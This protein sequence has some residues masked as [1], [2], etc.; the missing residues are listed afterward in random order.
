MWGRVVGAVS[1]DAFTRSWRSHFSASLIQSII[2]IVEGDVNR[3][4]ILPVVQIFLL[5]RPLCAQLPPRLERCLPY[6]TLAQEISQMQEKI[7][8][9]E[10]KP[11]PSPRVVIASVQYVLKTQIPASVRDR[12]NWSIKS[13]RL[14]DDPELSWLKEMEEVGMR[15]ALQDSGYFKAEVKANARLIDGNE[16]RRRYALT[17]YID[18][19]WLYKLG[20][21]RFERVDGNKILSF[22]VGE[23]RKQVQM[24]RG[25]V[26]NVSKIRDGIEE[27]SG[28]YATEGYIDMTMEP[29][30]QNDDDGGPIDLILKV[31]EEKQYHLGKVEFLGLSGESQN[32]LTPKLRPG[33]VFNKEI[34]D[35]ILESNKALVPLDASR[36]DVSL[37]RNVEEG[38]VDIRFDF[39]RCPGVELAPTIGKPP[40]F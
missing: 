35:E 17:L 32:Q 22:S 27:I 13:P 30:I 26:F 4:F 12:I 33:E 5:S 19:G 37:F 3:R 11:L 18:A 1:G 20:D 28:L 15:G 7:K 8:P 6:P 9:R 14:Y 29:E 34:V 25:E 23:L 2:P 31:N 36:K 38:T 21:V 40:R 10:P 24:K 16:R 39:Y